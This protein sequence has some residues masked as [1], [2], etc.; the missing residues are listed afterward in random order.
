MSE[1]NIQ[2]DIIHPLEQYLSGQVSEKDVEWYEWKWAVRSMKK[3]N[4]WVLR[5]ALTPYYRRFFMGDKDFFRNGNTDTQVKNALLELIEREGNY[6]GR[7]FN[8]LD[9]VNAAENWAERLMAD[10]HEPR[11]FFMLL[12]TIQKRDFKPDWNTIYDELRKKM[13]KAKNYG[14]FKTHELYCLLMGL[15]MIERTNLPR[16]KKNELFF[17]MKKNWSFMK[18]MYSVL[19]HYIVGMR[20]DNFAA[21]ANTVCNLKSARPHMHLFYKAFN[22][23]FDVLCPE[24]LIDTHSGKSVREQALV[25]KRRMEEIIKS[26]PPSTELEELCAILFPK[27]IKDVLRQSRPKTY[28]ELEADIDDLSKRYNKVLGQLTNA[29]R[30]VESDKISAEDLL[31]AFL[32]L[33]SELALAYYGNMSIL[34]AQNKTWQ[35]YAPVINERILAKQQEQ[36]DR[37]QELDKAVKKSLEE[38]RTQNIYG[39]K[40]EFTADS[41]LVKMELPINAD[42]VEVA[43]RIAVQ[44]KKQIE[45]K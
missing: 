38:P 42:P 16:E 17:F 1:Y 45:K 21:V 44:G 14:N 30:D 20:A 40:N 22:E 18:Y 32:R 9:I 6:A 5:E 34:M 36:Q 28:E 10:N 4:Y 3:E 26:T 31:A 19:I 37:Q 23:N 7:I 12:I 43:Q 29:V 2:R 27:V 24:G 11:Y 13:A 33:P 8:D 15:T 35:K 41:K 25:H 39:D